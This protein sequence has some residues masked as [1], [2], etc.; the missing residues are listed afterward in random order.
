MF[1]IWISKA[2]IAA[3]ENNLPKSPFPSKREERTVFDMVEIICQALYRV[4]MKI[5][6]VRNLKETSTLILY[7]K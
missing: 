4:Y 1:H 2:K 6:Y 3:H 5:E 7:K